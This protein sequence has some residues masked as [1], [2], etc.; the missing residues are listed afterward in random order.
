[1]SFNCERTIKKTQ[2]PHR[3]H[4]CLEIIPAGSE[5]NY[6]VGHYYDFYD[7]YQCL[8]CEEIICKYQDEIVDD[9]NSFPE[10]CVAEWRSGNE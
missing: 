5:C 7:I 6:H 4:Y 9:N 3:C 10:G 2:K 8:E 1:M